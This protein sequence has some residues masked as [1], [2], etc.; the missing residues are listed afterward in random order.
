LETAGD[1]SFTPNLE[2]K[3][4]RPQLLFALGVIVAETVHDFFRFIGDEPASLQ[5]TAKLRDLDARLRAAD[6]AH[7]IYL[8]KKDW[9]A[10]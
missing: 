9:P 2:W 3:Q 1:G 7:E 10:T 6:E 5:V 8:N 4:P